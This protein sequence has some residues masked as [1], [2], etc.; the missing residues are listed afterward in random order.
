MKK[1]TFMLAAC[2]SLSVSFA[3]AQLNWRLAGNTATT[4]GTDFLGT[5]DA[6]DL[7]IK[8]NNT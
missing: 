8:T 4:P 7:V 3:H 6:Q 2:M 5:T 1:N